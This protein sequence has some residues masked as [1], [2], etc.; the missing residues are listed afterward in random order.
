MNPHWYQIVLASTA[1][2]AACAISAY[3]FWFAVRHR[4][5]IFH[6]PAVGA[7]LV[8]VGLVGERNVVA[9]TGRPASVWDLSIKVPLI[10]LYLDVVTLIG[11]IIGLLGLSLILF[12]E[13]VVPPEQRWTPPPPRGLDEDDSV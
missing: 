8:V 3:C 6:V 1:V 12:L 11:L 9:A 5:A 2:L 7:A 4:N 13:R 10:P